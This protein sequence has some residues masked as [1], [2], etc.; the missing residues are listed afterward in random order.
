MKLKIKDMDVEAGTTRVVLLHHKDAKLIDIRPMDRVI[1]KKGKRQIISIADIAESSRTIKQGE[2]GFFDEPLRDLGAKEGDKVGILL[3]KKP[4]A[5]RHIK[6]KLGGGR[7][8]AKEMNEIVKST[9][10]NELSQIELAFFVSSCYLN[11]LSLDETISLTRSIVSN[12]ESLNLKNKRIVDKHCTGGVP[13][14]RTT[15][16]I[17]PIL[18]AAGLCVPK[19]SSR[20]ITS[21]AGTA[22]TMEVLAP[23]TVPAAKIKK[24]VEKTG[25]CIVWGGGVNLAAADDKLIKIRHPLSLDPEGMLLASILAKKHSVGATYVLI[26]IPVG[27]ETKIK[28]LRH[29]QHLKRKFKIV[30]GK[31]G[32]EIHVIF[33]NGNGPIGNGIGPTLEARDVLYL[34]RR[35]PRAPIDLERKC[36]RMAGKMLRENGFPEGISHARKLLD[37]GKAYEKMKEII[38]E[39]GGNPNISPDELRPAQHSFHVRAEKSGRLVNIDNFALSRV[40]SIAGAPDDKAAG[41][42]LF[43]HEK[44]PVWKGEVL[45][46]VYAGSAEKQ[47]FVKEMVARGTVFKING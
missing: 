14:N 8:N 23:V 17:V 37:S 20:S 40:A 36:L 15:M 44:D 22:D 10:N 2:I 24:I 18:A 5:V 47:K 16:V 38:K 12:G 1:L 13:G 27:K 28:S 7:L 46:T 30:G 39:Q 4:D 6:K 31:L 33:T 9:V 11:R 26:D 25:G 45:F 21:P 43:K 29:A 35:D 19:T 34:L 3:A 41:L 42:Y 32:M